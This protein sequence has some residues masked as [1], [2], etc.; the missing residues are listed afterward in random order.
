MPTKQRSMKSSMPFTEK[1]VWAKSSLGCSR[2]RMSEIERWR[3]C[4]HTRGMF[5]QEEPREH[6]QIGGGHDRANCFSPAALWRSSHSRWSH[7]P[8]GCRTITDI[9]MGNLE[10]G[11]INA[12]Q[13]G[14]RVNRLRISA[15]TTP[16][17]GCSA[18][19]NSFFFK[20]SP[21]SVSP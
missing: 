15:N 19:A 5:I 20:R 7:P 1:G 13:V 12:R 3:H 21:T 6:A 16:R 4:I 14:E 17:Q 9:H 10:R 8:F 2:S 11:L 18:M